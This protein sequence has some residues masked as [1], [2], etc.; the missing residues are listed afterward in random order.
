MKKNR[1]K[2]PKKAE[3]RD[4]ASIEKV[5]EAFTRSEEFMAEQMDQ[6]SRFYSLYR[7]ERK[8]DVYRVVTR[9]QY[10]VPVCYKAV[11]TI[12]PRL[13]SVVF[14]VTPVI[15]A[16]WRYAPAMSEGSQQLKN[17]DLLFDYY[18][19]RD[20]F[21]EKIQS[22]LKNTLIYGQSYL[23]V[24]WKKVTKEKKSTKVMPSID[25]NPLEEEEL[26]TLPPEMQELIETQEVEVTE[27]EIVEDHLDIQ[28][29]DILDL[30]FDPQAQFPDPF[31]TAKYVIHRTRKRKSDILALRDQGVYDEFDEEDLMP[32]SDEDTPGAKKALAAGRGFDDR[33][34]PADPMITIYEYWED[35][36][37]ITTADHRVQL[38]DEENPF[39]LDENKKQKPFIA[40]YDNLVPG[41]L[42][43]IGEVEPLE[44]T[45]VEISTLRRQRTDNNSLI[46]NKMF[47]FDKDAEVD[48]ESMELARP[49]GG[50]GVR[51]QGNPVSNVLQY[52]Q[53]GDINGASYKED[54]ALNKDAQE[55]SGLLDYAVGNAP[56]RREAATT[57]QLLQTAANHRFDIKIRNIS[58]CMQR[59]GYMM[60]ERWKQFL[61]KPISV[62][63]PGEGGYVMIDRKQLPPFEQVDL[64]APGSPGMLLKENRHQKIMQM[65][66]GLMQNQMANPMAALQMFILALKESDLDGIEPIIQALQQPAPPP[67]Q[68][69]GQGG[70]PEAGGPQ[71]PPQQSGPP[72]ANEMPMMPPPGSPER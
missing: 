4:M 10:V 36:R 61:T 14:S 64:T 20:F 70:S 58:Q 21:F 2:K 26:S 16:R 12:L 59:L 18:S 43:Q 33:G 35:D 22:W 15:Q 49:G 34:D 44:H 28:N 13:L 27:E 65:Y 60:F 41:E 57:V 52:I 23:K 48:T 37:V 30:F 31:G 46:I 66:M 56:E 3:A 17:I 63:V 6:Y 72:M 11:E 29:V 5:R 39:G 62:Q 42:F 1:E 69:P 7:S 55:I 19:D 71:A 32:S 45:Q 9:S 24:G 40:L 8:N 53:Q 67:M 38:R 25:G 68:P 54:E 47:L 51:T 50:V